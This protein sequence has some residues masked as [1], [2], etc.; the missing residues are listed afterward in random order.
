M[1]ERDFLRK[2]D[3]F[4]RRGPLLDHAFAGSRSVHIVSRNL[5]FY[6]AISNVCFGLYSFLRRSGVEVSLYCI[7]TNIGLRQILRDSAD[8]QL[9]KTKENIIF[10]C[11]SIYDSNLDYIRSLPCKKIFY[12]C[13]ITP[14][15]YFRKDAPQFVP[16][17]VKGLKGLNQA[18][19]F[20][21]HIAISQFIAREL[22]RYTDK[23]VDVVYPIFDMA[24]FDIDDSTEVSPLAPKR[25]G[26]KQFL[27]TGQIIPHKR[28]DDLFQ[29][30]EKYNDLDP[31][32]RLVIVGSP[33]GPFKSYR[34]KVLGLLD[35]CKIKDKVVFTGGVSQSELKSLY[36]TSDCYVTMSEHE[37][38][39]VPIAESFYCGL[40]VFCNDAGAMPEILGNDRYLFKSADHRANAELLHER[41]ASYDKDWCTKRFR[42]LSANFIGDKIESIFSGL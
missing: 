30:F 7:D 20:D 14:P 2:I 19:E 16:H 22:R 12:Y 6:D 29:L 36:L 27:F 39:C 33:Q 41:L 13:G 35:R 18:G 10:Y 40:P 11:Y 25:Q 8:I 17:L 42:E 32:F 31:N 37:G 26:T 23:H 9:S 38:F 4:S 1:D 5:Q 24:Y 34:D 21:R 28:V 3:A 15:K